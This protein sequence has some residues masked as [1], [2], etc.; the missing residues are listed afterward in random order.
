MKIMGAIILLIVFDVIFVF[1][2]IRVWTTDDPKNP[3]WHALRPMHNFGIFCWVVIMILKVA[4]F[5]YADRPGGF[6]W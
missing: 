2:E 6:C 1:T 5:R 4:F 3:I